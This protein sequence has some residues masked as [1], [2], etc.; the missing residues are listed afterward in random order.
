[1]LDP[2]ARSVRW[3]TYAVSVL[4]GAALWEFAGRR[5]N[6]AVAAPLSATLLR[7]WEMIETGELRASLGGSLALFVAGFGIALLTALTFGLLLS[8]A[9]VLRVALSDYILLVN[10]MPMVALI[11][12][13]LSIFG[14]ELGAKVLVVFL[15]CFFPILYN[16]I[17]GA[18][19]VRPELIEVARSYR[20]GEWAIWRDVMLPG[21]FPYAMTGVRQAIGRG[22]VGVV[23][24]EF[25]LSASGIGQLLMTSGRNFDTAG[26]LATVLVI[27]LLGVALMA[28]GRA[29]ERDRAGAAPGSGQRRD[30]A[31]G[32]RH[33]PGG[34]RGAPD[35]GR[36]GHAD[37]P[38]HGPREAR[39][40]PAAALRERALRDADGRHP[41]AAHHLV[42]L[43]LRGAARDGG[44]RRVLPDRDERRRRSALRPGR[45]PGGGPR[46][47]RALDR[48]LV[49]NHAAVLP[50]VPA[51]RR[52]PRGRARAGG[53]RGGGVLHL[54]RWSRLFHP[55]PVADLPPR[56]RLRRRAAA[57]RLRRRDG[58]AHRLVDA[59]ALALV[60]DR[61]QR[62]LT[63]HGRSAPALRDPSP[64]SSRWIRAIV[65]TRQAPDRGIASR[66][67]PASFPHLP[68]RL[69]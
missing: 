4:G 22:L 48:R 19:S 25:F 20:S 21:T 38:R 13:I 6:A 9:R 31:S 14:L 41:A 24:A 68:R 46:L 50:A 18:D 23:A 40:P 2:E 26:L 36:L 33:A 51:G 3:A 11:P 49:R 27:T 44:L 62:R 17:E 69:M 37:R 54:H 28:L 5:A 67:R 1:M 57:R 45:V 64:G 16:T 8:R 34:G 43:Q 10:A 55:L 39:R 60:P 15:F 63:Q 7:L 29:L 59:A 58:R 12:F 47:P 53:R 52:A 61:R 56:R 32:G 30:A 66:H 65:R 35:R 42:R